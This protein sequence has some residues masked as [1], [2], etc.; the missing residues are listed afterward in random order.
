ME[1]RKEK[2]S[3]LLAFSVKLSSSN[4]ELT[5][6]RSDWEAKVKEGG[7][8]GG[9]KLVFRCIFV[10]GGDS[11]LRIGYANWKSRSDQ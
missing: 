3:E 8:G 9:K 10:V 1:K 11:Q 2:E 5:A 4:A 6:E 7:G